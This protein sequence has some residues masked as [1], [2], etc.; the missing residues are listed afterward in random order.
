MS[1][2]P[3]QP[4]AVDDV[5]VPPLPGKAGAKRQAEREAFMALSKTLSHTPDAAPQRL[6]ETAMRLTGGDSAGIS[7]ED[8]EGEEMVF[9]WVAVAGEF[10]RY[11]NGT[12]PRFFS[13]CGTVLERRQPLVMRDPVRHFGYISQLHVPV[14]SALLVPFGRRGKLIGTVWVAAHKQEKQ[15]TAEDVRTV[16]GLT[17]FSTSIL[18]AVENLHRP[19]PS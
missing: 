16:Q 4:C 12:M 13:P 9:R 5:I 14:R 19:R 8:K 18:D 3:P 11:L 6:V 1:D 10:S 17:T 2:S 15:F 7:L